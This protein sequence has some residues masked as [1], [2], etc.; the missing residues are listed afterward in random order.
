MSFAFCYTWNEAN[1][2]TPPQNS[3]YITQMY[4]RQTGIYIGAEVA[5]RSTKLSTMQSLGLKGKLEVGG[6]WVHR[7][8]WN[9]GKIT[10]AL[11]LRFNGRPELFQ[12]L[13][14]LGLG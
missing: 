7:H 5:K 11:C 10:E 14:L 12:G 13:H 2:C 8:T 3:L 9:V 4:N 6:G 1:T